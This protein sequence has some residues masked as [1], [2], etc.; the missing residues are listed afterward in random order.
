M[1]TRYLIHADKTHLPVPLLAGIVQ[2][3]V[4]CKLVTTDDDGWIKW[5]GGDCPL[6]D[7][8]RCSIRASCGSGYGSDLCHHPE[9]WRW[10]HK[11]DYNNITAYR[12]IYEEAIT[13]ETINAKLDL[14]LERLS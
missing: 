9:K 2:I 14:I 7:G 3:P 1:K 5:N 12:P 13:L 8:A 10:T 6:E 11:Q 4:G